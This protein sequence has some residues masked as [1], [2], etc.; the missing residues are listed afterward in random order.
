MDEPGAEE[1][2]EDVFQMPEMCVKWECGMW[3]GGPILA[4]D[5][6]GFMCCPCC[7]ASYGRLDKSIG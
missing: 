1:G 6:N 3:A 4:A 5:E 7:G 2:G